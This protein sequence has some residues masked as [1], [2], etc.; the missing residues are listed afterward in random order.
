MLCQQRLDEINNGSVAKGDGEDV[1]RH[2]RHG[3]SRVAP[4]SHL[5]AGFGEY[6]LIELGHQSCLAHQRDESIWRD[7]S[8]LRMNPA[9]KCLDT[10]KLV[11]VER[12]LGLV[13][14]RQL[15]GLQGVLE[16]QAQCQF[17][18]G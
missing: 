13:M 11:V 2:T 3:K 18:I 17:V 16:G 1:D 12:Y 14:Q 4:L 5:P 15:I 7:V 10:K 9:G 8:K 6:P